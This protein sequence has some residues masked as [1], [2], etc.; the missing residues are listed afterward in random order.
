MSNYPNQ[1]DDDASIIRVDD[2]LT[3][4]GALAINQLRD[5]VF[6]IEQELGL[7]LSGSAGTLFDRLGVSIEASGALKSS[8]IVAA[9]AIV[10]PVANADVSPTAG[11]V[12]S[13]LSLTYSTQ[14]LYNDIQAV[15]TDVDNIIDITASL[16]LD[17]LKHLNGQNPLSSSAN[18]RHVVSHIDI[19]DEP[20]D[21]RDGAYS[22]P[23]GVAP[24]SKTGSLRGSN[25][26]AFLYSMND[27]LVDHQNAT[28]TASANG[29]TYGH[30]AAAISVNS[31]EFVVLSRT[32]ADMQGFA[33]AVDQASFAANANH[34]QNN[35][36]NG[37]SR[38]CRGTI[39]S[40]DGYGQGLVPFTSVTTF[41]ATAGA[42]TLIDNNVN[43]DDII[44][45]TPTP[46]VTYYFDSLFSQVRSGDIITVNY[47]AVEAQ[48]VIDSVSYTFDG[49]NPPNRS[50]L[51]RINGRN[52]VDTTNAV[53]RIDRP[54]FSDN[55]F[56]VLAIS[57]AN[58]SFGEIPSVTVSNPRGAAALGI[59]FNADKLNRKHYNLYLEFYPTGN[60]FDKSLILPAID[61]TGNLGVTP[62]K[63]T[64][65][66]VVESINSAFRREGYNYRFVAFSNKGEIGIMLA[67]SISN[68]SFSIISG[69]LDV[70]GNVIEDIFVNN[71]VGDATTG[72]VD[73][74]GFGVAGANVASP[75]FKT[76]YVNI[77]QSQAATRVFVPL[78]SK[79]YYVNGNERSNL[80]AISDGYTDVYG[81]R[82]WEATTLSKTVIP[83]LTVKVKYEV[84]MDLRT[85]DLRPGKTIVVQP[86]LAKTDIKYNDVDYGRFIISDVAYTICGGEC[87]K[88]TIE[89]YNGVHATG[90]AIATTTI[91]IAVKLYFSD[92]SVSFNALNIANS[93]SADKFKRL[94]EVY[95][96]SDGHTFSHERARY[97][98]STGNAQI[99]KTNLIKVATKLRG[100]LSGGIRSINLRITSYN[101]TTGVYDGYLGKS[102][103]LNVGPVVTGKKGQVT[104]FYDETGV[105]YIDIVFDLADTVATFAAVDISI[106]L[107]ESLQNDQEVFFLGTVLYNELSNRLIYL[108]DGRQFGNLSEN[109]FSNSAIDFV[110][111]GD[112]FTH[113]NGVVRGLTYVSGTNTTDS[114]L[115]TF[116]GGLVLVNGKFSEI[117][118]F[119]A[120]IPI[121]QEYYAGAPVAK[122]TWAVCI[123]SKS[124]V[125][126]IPL[127]DYDILG[128]NIA[129]G[130]TRL[131]SVYNPITTATY[132]IDCSTFTDL[133]VKRKDLTIIALVRSNV[134]SSV[135][136][137]NTVTDAR[138]IIQD[139]SSAPVITWT[140]EKYS[141]NFDSFESLDTWLKFNSSYNNTVRVRGD[142][143]FDEEYT[144][145]YETLVKFVGDGATFT[146]SGDTVFNIGSNVS[147]DGIKFVYV[148]STDGSY[149]TNN[150]VNSTSGALFC[151]VDTNENIEV[152]NCEFTA[153]VAARHPFL[154][155]N[156]SNN[157]STLQNVNISNNKFV[158]T[159]AADDKRAVIAFT[160]PAAILTSTT[161]ARLT[162]CV[163]D[164]NICDKNQMISISSNYN[165]GLTSTRN[166]IT[167][168]NCRITNNVCGAINYLT[169]QATPSNVYNT[170]AITDKDNNLIISGNTCRF[171]FTG[172]NNG[173]FLIGTVPGV[174]PATT[175]STAM[176]SGSAIITENTV[177]WI[178]ISMR[179]PSSLLVQNPTLIIKHNKISGFN[180]TF[181]TEYYYGYTTV[182]TA[183]I[184]DPVAGA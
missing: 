97:N 141:G 149:T 91:A 65:D 151:E 107:F 134:I 167:T 128:S 35:H 99:V 158:Y 59:G 37:I 14:S 46:D 26:A 18:A 33:D 68:A 47:G 30:P 104:R 129:T 166:A 161:A 73:P 74:F 61:V 115:L 22:W 38:T 81:D 142:F 6:A 36:T 152:K 8:A 75:Q 159:G 113:Q 168:I 82:Y 80:R 23:S 42:S 180:P 127:T 174:R 54:K 173:I 49:S 67:D 20:T 160:A 24:R 137:S 89:V 182:N 70:S 7:T 45:F 63:Y 57:H 41:L 84:P 101:T 135:S 72:A 139:D 138:K 164:G 102:S 15:Q 122:I 58:N 179:V 172:M 40:N 19:N 62:S 109:E 133:A 43:G 29:D 94:F 60:P 1:L 87:T 66:S 155:F 120:S 124:D 5:A 100:Y 184:V 140:S 118:N 121:V 98:L 95:V 148:A 178:H 31:D 143:T 157:T 156:Y 50:Y 28:G 83:T 10:G 125:Q 110:T 117:N 146:L 69:S 147:F 86:T 85:A 34:Q 105:D 112:R 56:G 92:D 130:T 44:Q 17:F 103:V 162:N 123:N 93:T 48:Y 78:K 119:V 96:D 16:S 71:V 169:R 116:Q 106:D 32:I 25:L 114:M 64:L 153:S 171:I 21:S 11:I 170:T 154:V 79:N 76:S 144:F 9:G 175:F 163:I 165:T 27:E 181:L 77:N 2:N 13:K 132:G 150:L 52:L 88:T 39:L 3:D 111:A 53:A 108:R 55:K 126:I 4:I 183:V 51:V 136:F 12:E 177:S 176:F 90:N 145:D 131:I